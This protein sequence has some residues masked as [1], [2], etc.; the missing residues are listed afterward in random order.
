MDESVKRLSR[1]W[2][3]T[4]SLPERPQRVLQPLLPGDH[5]H[6][7]PR[8]LSISTDLV[9]AYRLKRRNACR[10]TITENG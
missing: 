7:R 6:R 9:L 8:H 3:D 1:L 2:R 10:F 5:Q 4:P